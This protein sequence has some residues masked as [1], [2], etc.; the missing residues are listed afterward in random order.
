MPAL[1]L[2]VNSKVGSAK[3]KRRKQG[4]QPSEGHLGGLAL[5]GLLGQSVQTCGPTVGPAVKQKTSGLPASLDGPF[6]KNDRNGPDLL[7]NFSCDSWTE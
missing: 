5:A 3:S 7:R 2:L 6:L 4:C 1:W